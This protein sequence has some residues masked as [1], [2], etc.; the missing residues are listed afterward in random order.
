MRENDRIFS[1][2]NYSLSL[3]MGG[4]AIAM[5]EKRG[6]DR[7]WQFIRALSKGQSV[8]E[9]FSENEMSQDSND[10]DGGQGP[11]PPT[12]TLSIGKWRSFHDRDGSVNGRPPGRL[13]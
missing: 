10:L 4:V 1:A 11:S 13:G 7:A 6:S 2:E 8:V 9:A 5:Y 3:R 12:N